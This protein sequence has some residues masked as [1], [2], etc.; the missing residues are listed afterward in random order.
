[1]YE[2]FFVAEFVPVADLCTGRFAG[3]SGNWVMYAQTEPFLLG[4][5][6][7]L[8]YSWHGEGTLTFQKGR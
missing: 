2:A 3:V 5:S 8:P 6:D 1:V 4:S 7:P